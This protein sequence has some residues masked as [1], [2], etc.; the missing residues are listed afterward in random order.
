MNLGN[1][2]S[3]GD[4]SVQGSPLGVFSNSTVRDHIVR[5]G[6]NYHFGAAP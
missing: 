6:P 5:I 1:I 4:F 3:S 2:S